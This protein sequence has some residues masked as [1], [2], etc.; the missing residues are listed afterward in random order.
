MDARP[1]AAGFAFLVGMP[2]TGSTLLRHV[3]NRSPRLIIAIGDALPGPQSAAP[4]ARSAREG[5]QRRRIAQ[6]HRCR[7]APP[8]LLALAG[9]QRGRRRARN[10]PARDRP[11]RAQ[12][13]RADADALR[14][15][16]SGRSAVGAGDRREDAGAP[17]RGADPG[18]VVSRCPDRSYRSRP[19]RGLRLPAAASAAGGVGPQGAHAV[20]AWLAR[21]STV[22]ADRDDLRGAELERRR[23]MG[24]PPSGRARWAL[25]SH[26]VRGPGQRPG[27][28]GP[29]ESA[30]SSACRSYR[31]CSSTPDIVG[32]SFSPIG[33]RA[34]VS[35]RPSPIAGVGRSGPRRGGSWGGRPAVT[36]AA[37]AIDPDRV[38]AQS[39]N[40]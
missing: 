36:W 32:S 25:P 3:L 29:R 34:P 17:R 40:A 27:G 2:R 28:D 4:P 26:P 24:P 21:Q 1:G 16:P 12:P 7:P 5:P 15:G 35:T 22:A 38:R 33:M 31:R 20:A 37:S 6:R 30:H 18:R 8:Q 23:E 19:A 14:R 13:V 9:S 11:D 39:S 10:A